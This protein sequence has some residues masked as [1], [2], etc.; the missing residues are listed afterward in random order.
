MNHPEKYVYPSL[1][2]EYSLGRVNSNERMSPVDDKSSSEFDH[3][4][5]NSSLS[6]ELQVAANLPKN[7][8]TESSF[9]LSPYENSSGEEEEQ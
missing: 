2:R 9:S 7:Q 6:S 8:P 4:E 3:F 1:A 5:M